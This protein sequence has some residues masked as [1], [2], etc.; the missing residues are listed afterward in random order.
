MLDRINA[1]G[2]SARDELVALCRG[3]VA[4]PSANPPGDTTA[5][6]GV[7]LE[8]LARHGIPAC[9][10]SRVETMPN[11]VAT[12]HGYG[13]GRHLILN[14]HMDTMPPGD[15]ASWTVP[16]FELTAREGRL[17]GL[18][19]GNMKGAVAAMCLAVVV[20]DRARDAWPGSVTFTAVSDECVFGDNG[21]AFL[22]ATMP[23]LV[24]DALICGEGPGWM[25]L[26]I[27]E[28]GVAW[29]EL[30][31]SGPGGHASNASA[32]GSA[33]SRLA[34][35]VLELERLNDL[36]VALPRALEH[37]TSDGGAEGSRL[38]V[39]VGTFRGGTFVSQ[40][41]TAAVAEVDFRI[42]PGLTV[43]EVEQMVASRACVVPGVSWRRTRSWEPNWTALD[44]PIGRATSAAVAATRGEPAV[45][46][47][48]LPAS[49]ASRWRALGVPA[50]CFGPQPTLSAGV[51]DYAL[52]SDVADCARIYASAAL[53][54]LRSTAP[55]SR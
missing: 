12:V 41:P 17:Y 50:I 21:A 11:V 20:L 30:T 28:K 26:A 45:P 8:F 7:V 51:D 29:F 4:A 46:T 9:T 19:M 52:E 54:Y 38:S 22:L 39:N 13:P 5:V 33:V 47:V 27:A 24:G 53:D 32:G 48:R 23:E 3:L 34:K 25:R 1:G 31:A 37:M 2:D 55:G 40:I 43:S 14:V 16:R 49:D 15:E 10:L 35:V 44:T 6:A 42:P 36:E 18:G